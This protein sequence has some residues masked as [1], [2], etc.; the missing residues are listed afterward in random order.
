V[1]EIPS[2][3]RDGVRLAALERGAGDPPL[4]FVHGWCCDHGYFAPQIEHFTRR[5]R[6]VAPDLRG[7]GR[8]DRPPGDYAIA[9]FAD[10][11]A[12]L[13]REL[14]LRRPVVVGHSLGAAVALAL[15][16]RHPEIPAAL[17]LLD[18]AVFFA[19]AGDELRDE[20]LAGLAGPGH[21]SEAEE[22]IREFLF[23]PGDD[24]ELRERIVAAMCATPQHVMHPA[25]RGLVD[26]DSAAAAKACRAPVLV[27]EAGAPFVDRARL[28][29]ALPDVAI[30]ST[31]GVG[32]F[33]QIL[34][35]ERV[36]AIL[37]RFLSG[38]GGARPQR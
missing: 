37:E 30:E 10:D 29:A 33:H 7:F 3:V 22:F 27:V 14:G 26:F 5:H 17:A 1:T 8:S 31:P 38:L 25:L 19:E 32:H 23:L 18:P 4:L 11:V 24:P 34:A 12:W 16:A 20:L 13:C 35:P 9:T 6:V 2:Y 28:R 21:R 15:A 36:N